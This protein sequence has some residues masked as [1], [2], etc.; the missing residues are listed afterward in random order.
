[1]ASTSD[2][3]PPKPIQGSRKGRRRKN[4]EQTSDADVIDTWLD[5]RLRAIY[6]NDLNDPLPE[7]MVALVRSGTKRGGPAS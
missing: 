7:D 4:V 3:G 6:Q 2:S 1:M 5:Q